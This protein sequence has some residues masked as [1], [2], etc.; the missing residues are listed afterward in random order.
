[1]QDNNIEI[2]L[3]PMLFGE[4]Y[5]DISKFYGKIL[6]IDLDDINS[7]LIEPI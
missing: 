7:E 4:P 5:F 1:M 6:K 2:D 3:F